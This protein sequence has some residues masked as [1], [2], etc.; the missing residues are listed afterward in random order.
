MKS[1]LPVPDLKSLTA[2]DFFDMVITCRL[3]YIGILV[4]AI[5]PISG[6]IGTMY[7]QHMNLAIL[8][9][10]GVLAMSPMFFSIAIFAVAS[11]Q[12]LIN[13]SVI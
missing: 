12:S 5:Y 1:P 10:H 9:S 8:M 2:S 11:F 4:A 6:I 13:E 7:P 3:L